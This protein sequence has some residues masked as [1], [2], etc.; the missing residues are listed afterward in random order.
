M[1]DSAAGARAAGRKRDDA[2]Q[3]LRADED[4]ITFS[5]GL[6][7]CHSVSDDTMIST[8][9][10]YGLMGR[11]GRWLDCWLDYREGDGPKQTPGS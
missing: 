3:R 6:V 2:R 5:T 7:V 9:A 8:L 11:C 1:P 4:Q 10:K